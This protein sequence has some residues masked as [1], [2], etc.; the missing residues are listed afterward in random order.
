MRLAYH[1]V[2]SRLRAPLPGA[3]SRRSC[4]SRSLSSARAVEGRRRRVYSPPGDGRK[5]PAST[6]QA[7]LFTSSCPGDGTDRRGRT[8]P[9]TRS[10]SCR[11][12]F[13]AVPGVTCRSQHSTRGVGNT[14]PPSGSRFGFQCVTRE[15]IRAMERE[16]RG[17]RPLTGRRSRKRGGARAV[18][19][20]R[21]RRVPV[22]WPTL[23]SSS[24]LTAD[25]IAI[26][27]PVRAPASSP[28]TKN[29]YRV[30]PGR[31][32]LELGDT[33]DRAPAAGGVSS[34]RRTGGREAAVGH[35]AS[36]PSERSLALARHG[37][38][39]I[40]VEGGRK[41]LERLSA[42]LERSSRDDLAD[43][44]AVVAGSPPSLL[45]RK[46]AASTA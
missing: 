33:C 2:D 4:S 21:R 20:R 30:S 39:A 13:Q 27:K 19:R 37:A 28:S 45:P 17:G 35:C 38:G 6:L 34:R 36:Q 31:A 11:P 8:G 9:S 23:T 41:A 22:T 25:D 7:C 29:N 43:E 14:V 10:R 1:G 24:R 46:R 18:E 12:S 44:V 16:Q 40:G 42:K 5:R 3:C 26:G 15:C 32:R